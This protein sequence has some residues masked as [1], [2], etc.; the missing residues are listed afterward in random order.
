MN[1][2]EYQRLQAERGELDK[3][4]AQ[5]PETDAIDRMSL[6][7][8]K[9]SIEKVLATVPTPIREPVRAKLT[10]RGKPVV[11]SYGILAEFG[12]LAVNRFADAIAA[13]A[14]SMAGPLGARGAIP[15]RD[16]FQ[17]LITG[18]ALGSFGFELEERAKDGEMYFEEFSS[19]EPAIDKASALMKASLGSDDDL[20]DAAS[21]IDPRALI[22]LRDFLR[23]LVEHEA[24]CSLEYK[25]KCFRFCDS[26]EV[27]RSQE[28]LSQDNIREKEEQIEGAFQGVLPKRRTFEFKL[29]S[30]QEIIAGKVGAGIADAGVINRILNQPTKICVHTTCVGTGR[31]RYV[32]LKYEEPSSLE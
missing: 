14:A 19:I 4:L 26:G 25:D 31:P 20:A 29:S 27:R 15:N 11:K 13:F 16:D 3:L 10:F 23:T 28:R 9:D 22:S 24:I 30:T 12:A 8:R 18:T 17:L 2:H 21:D 5:T 7:S 1:L 32:L 6:Q